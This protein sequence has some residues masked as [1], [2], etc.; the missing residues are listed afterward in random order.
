MGIFNGLRSAFILLLCAIVGALCWAFNLSIENFFAILGCI[1]IAV[2]IIC[3][4]FGLF[5][6]G[7][8]I[9]SAFHMSRG[10]LV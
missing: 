5:L 8:A 10:R 3:V 7:V 1:V 2:W 6:V 4:G 9:R